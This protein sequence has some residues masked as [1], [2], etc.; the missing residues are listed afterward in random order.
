MKA[1]IELEAAGV[2]GATKEPKVTVPSIDWSQVLHPPI[3]LPKPIAP[4]ES[5]SL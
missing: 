2:S 4:I 3:I 5:S 1:M